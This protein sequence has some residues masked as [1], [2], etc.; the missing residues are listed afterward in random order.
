MIH[1]EDQDLKIHV[2]LCEERYLQLDA[3]IGKLEEKIDEI[4]AEITKNKHDLSRIILGSVATLTTSIL[5]LI[6]T[7]LLKF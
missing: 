4:K 2:S 3:R 1:G 6:T 5:G 7:I